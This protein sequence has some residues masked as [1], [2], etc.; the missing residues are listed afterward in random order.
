[1]DGGGLKIRASGG[2]NVRELAITQISEDR[3]GLGARPRKNPFWIRQDMSARD[4][5]ILPAIVVEI[6]NAVS[7]AGHLHCGPAHTAAGSGIVEQH[8]SSIKQQGKALLFECG[9]PDGWATRVGHVAEIDA[10]R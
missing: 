9:I 1:M 6:V 2:A 3:V 5:Q 7:P 4:K 8:V 10:H